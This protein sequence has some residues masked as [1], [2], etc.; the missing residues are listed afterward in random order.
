LLGKLLETLLPIQ[1]LPFALDRAHEGVR[2][3]GGRCS[4]PGTR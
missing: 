2:L 3:A 1:L 4:R